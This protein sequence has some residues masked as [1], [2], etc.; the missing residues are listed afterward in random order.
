MGPEIMRS[1]LHK[2]F[3]FNLYHLIGRWRWS[4]RDGDGMDVMRK[5]G[6]VTQGWEWRWEEFYLT[7][8]LFTRENQFIVDNPPRSI[9]YE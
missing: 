7:H 2:P 1:Y 9:F 4:K 3:G 8:V 6:V 5:K